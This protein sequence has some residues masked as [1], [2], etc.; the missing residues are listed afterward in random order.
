[1]ERLNKDPI[2]FDCVKMI[3]TLVQS[4]VKFS[5][6]YKGDIKNINFQWIHKYNYI[7]EAYHTQSFTI[8]EALSFISLIEKN[9]NAY[10][11]KLETPESIESFKKIIKD[12]NEYRDQLNSYYM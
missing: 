11:D 5:E 3:D 2:Y 1:M 10:V 12:I 8:D 4:L 7:S 6:D 9:C